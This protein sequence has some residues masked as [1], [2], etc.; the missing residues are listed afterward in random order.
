MDKSEIRQK[1]KAVRKEL[2]GEITYK[3]YSTPEYTNAEKIFCFY[4]FGSEIDTTKLIKRALADGKSVAL[5]CVKEGQSNM[6]FISINS[7]D[8]LV[9]DRYGIPSPEYDENN[10]HFGKCVV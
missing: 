1:F 7:V 10:R 2:A 4:S 3:F 6:V 8:G 5:P 9:K